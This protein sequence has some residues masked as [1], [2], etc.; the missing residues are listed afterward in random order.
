MTKSQYAIHM[1]DGRPVVFT[2]FFDSVRRVSGAHRI[3]D[4]LIQG[5]H[6]VK[7]CLTSYS[8]NF[9]ILVAS[10]RFPGRPDLDSPSMFFVDPD[11]LIPCIRSAKGEGA[12]DEPT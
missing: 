2:G 11:E 3:V 10:W 5:E 6:P 12:P 4:L 7:L 9:D 8:T 1:F